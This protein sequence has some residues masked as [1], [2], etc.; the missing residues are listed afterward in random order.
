MDN[1]QF[2]QLL[3]AV[4]AALNPP[5]AAL[6]A[7]TAIPPYEGDAI[8]LSSRPGLSLFQEGKKP[9]DCKFDGKLETLFQFQADLKTKA[10][11]CKWNTGPHDIFN[12]EIVPAVAPAP[13][14]TR[15]I[16]TEYGNITRAQIDAARTTRDADASLRPKQNALM[17]FECLYGSLIGTAKD[18]LI[19][20]D[21]MINDGPTLLYN[22]LTSTFTA[23]FSSAQS[24]R[25]N[26]STFEPRRVKYNVPELNSAI[27]LAVQ[28]IRSAGEVMNQE[29]FHYQFKIYKKIKSPTEW[30]SYLMHLENT[31]GTNHAYTPDQLYTDV[32]NQYNKLVN[33]GLWKP[34]DRFPEQQAIAMIAQTKATTDAAKEK[35]DKEKAAKDKNSNKP[36]FAKSESKEGDTKQWK[37]DTFHFCP[38]TNHKNGHW[39]KHSPAEC[40]TLKKERGTSSGGGGAS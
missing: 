29:I 35:A 27:R 14:V 11:L 18:R 31:I 3:A 26:L 15:N 23:T 4:A 38:S 25:E 37:G 32:E 40:N 10:D 8:D 30:S 7:L 34:A 12:I 21:D 16:M 20:E 2:Q 13:A 5:P 33:Q 36:P 19:S 22:I 24:T 39:H 1:A 17:M 9:L 28:K 6:V